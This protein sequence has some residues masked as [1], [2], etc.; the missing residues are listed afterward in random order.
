MAHTENLDMLSYR[1]NC[2]M[3][4]QG[5]GSLLEEKSKNVQE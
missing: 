4:S 5:Q 3:F 1:K 2:D